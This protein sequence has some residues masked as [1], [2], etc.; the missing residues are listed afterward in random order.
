MVLK[1]ARRFDFFFSLSPLPASLAF[2]TSFFSF[3]GHCF[4]QLSRLGC[5]SVTHLTRLLLL[6]ICVNSGT[7]TNWI[8]MKMKTLSCNSESTIFYVLNKFVRLM[9]KAEVITP[10]RKDGGTPLIRSPVEIQ[11]IH[12]FSLLTLTINI[13]N[14]R[15]SPFQMVLVFLPSRC[16]P[17][18]SY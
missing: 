18:E 16:I 10:V 15:S 4:F 8:I 13:P 5:Q 6:T 7:R 11:L 14:L 3:A 1:V 17:L 2:L 9:R 12:I